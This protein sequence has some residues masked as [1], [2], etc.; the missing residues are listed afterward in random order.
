MFNFIFKKLNNL[1]VIKF[2]LVLLLFICFSTKVVSQHTPSVY[3]INDL[4][5]RIHNNSDTI[6]VV[7]FWATWCKPCVAE[8][9]DF[10]KI[11]QE[12]KNKPVKVILVSLDFKENLN[13]KL[14]PFIN[15]NH[16]TTEVVLLDE[17]DGNNFINKID[18]GWSGAIPA[19]LF[20]KKEEQV[21]MEKKVSYTD[22]KGK[23]ITYL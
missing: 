21:F 11:E 12:Y 3:K 1:K 19:T 17:I 8:L 23:I 22:L 16:Y 10:E 15:K 5:H 14:I 18:K 13:N 4:L 7:N 9:P 6:Y 2:N 20:R